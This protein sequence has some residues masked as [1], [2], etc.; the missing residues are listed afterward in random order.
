MQLRST[1][2]VK[3]ES[4]R[5]RLGER[6]ERDRFKEREERERKREKEKRERVLQFERWRERKNRETENRVRPLRSTTARTGLTASSA[7]VEF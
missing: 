4:D 6:T 3:M 7:R 1:T 2:K 5:D